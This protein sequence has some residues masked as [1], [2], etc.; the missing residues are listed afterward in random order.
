M[1]DPKD[2]STDEYPKPNEG[3]RAFENPKFKTKK[4]GMN[5]AKEGQ[6][7]VRQIQWV[8]KD[9]TSSKKRFGKISSYMI[10]DLNNFYD[11]IMDDHHRFFR[12]MKK[13]FTEKYVLD[14]LSNKDSVDG[15]DCP[16]PTVMGILHDFLESLDAKL[17]NNRDT[18]QPNG[19]FMRTTIRKKKHYPLARTIITT[20]DIRTTIAL[21]Q[22]FLSGNIHYLEYPRDFGLLMGRFG[23]EFWDSSHPEDAEYMIWLSHWK[24]GNHL[25]GPQVCV[26]I[27]VDSSFQKLG[28]PRAVS[29]KPP[30]LGYLKLN[31][32]GSCLPGAVGG[33][34]LVR[35]ASGLPLA[36]FS[37]SFGV[38]SY[39]EAEA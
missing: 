22:N 15:F 17:S 33:G 37:N 16:R 20:S 8:V 2:S 1:A 39:M 24:F 9:P 29:W 10:P 25:E 32:D 4:N 31:V 23:G 7:A 26:S 14:S 18:S 3:K 34:G 13:S 28:G 27:I 12:R 6:T 30:P 5:L 19:R 35:T 36:G 38:K 21:S 11:E